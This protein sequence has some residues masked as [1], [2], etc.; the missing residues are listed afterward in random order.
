MVLPLLHLFVQLM[1]LHL[2]KVC[3]RGFVPCVMGALPQSTDSMSLDLAQGRKVIN[4]M[5]HSS[6]IKGYSGLVGEYPDGH[7]D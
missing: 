5:C 3:K 7:A 4:K 2:R 1:R 6:E